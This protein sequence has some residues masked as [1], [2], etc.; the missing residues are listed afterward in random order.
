MRKVQVPI[1]IKLMSFFVII[2]TISISFYVYYAVNMFKEDKSAYVFES[3]KL[4]G[5]SLTKLLSE[6]FSQIKNESSTLA[7]LVYNPVVLKKIFD[8]NKDLLS[9]IKYDPKKKSILKQVS[10]KSFNKKKL[11]L[12]KVNFSK[13]QSFKV[14]DDLLIYSSN[15]KSKINLTLYKIKSI[16]DLIDES[17]L[18]TYTLTNVSG[19]NILNSSSDKVLINSLIQR[20]SFLGL[21]EGTF[22]NEVMGNRY[23]VAYGMPA[24][25]LY[26]FTSVDERKAYEASETLVSKS[27]YYGLLIAA[28]TIIIVMF[29]SKIFTGPIRKLFDASQ[30]FSQNKFDHKVEL[31]NRDE[32]GVLADSFNDMSESIVK[33]MEQMEEKSRLESEMKTAKLVQDSFFPINELKSDKFSLKAFY[34]PASECGGDWWGKVEIDKKLIFLM[35]DATGHGTGAALVTA[36]AHNCLTYIEEAY[37]IDKGIVDS[38]EQILNFLNKSISNIHNDMMATGFIGIFDLD[39]KEL[40]YSNASHNPPLILRHSEN[41]ITK[42][43]ITPIIGNLGKRLGEDENETY[44]VDILTLASKDKVIFYTDGLT[45]GEN[46]S[47][48]QWGKRNF[49]KELVRT[50]NMSIADVVD[51]LVSNSYE[52]YNEKP[53]DDDITIVGVEL[54]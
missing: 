18:Y 2:L 3:V 25:D 20:R 43:D 10:S 14:V 12:A 40:K 52:F 42:N 36:M 24:Q 54:I 5:D 47:G 33:Y 19:Q 26:L 30:L 51:G 1:H 44:S 8:K 31:K 21:K 13:G 22:I 29:Y 16:S 7:E 9:Y 39:S 11:D 23:I 35:I 37:K 53:Q 46:Q 28:L 38:P 27:F 34:S 6:R 49:L 41:V 4:Q 45:E 32:L 50:G 17:F 15:L 48:K